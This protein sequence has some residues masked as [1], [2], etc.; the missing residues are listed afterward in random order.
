MAELAG[1]E[2]RRRPRPRKPGGAEQRLRAGRQHGGRLTRTIVLGAL[3]V[4]LGIA[5]LARELELDVD[6][7]LGYA[8]TSLL[9]VGGLVALALLGAIVLRL[10]R[11]LFR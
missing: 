2:R 10:L 11:R 6:E 4:L 5:W 8:L 1:V 9:L 7:L 3:V